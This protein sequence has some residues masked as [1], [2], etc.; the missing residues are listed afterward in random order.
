M[1]AF[2][3]IQGYGKTLRLQLDVDTLPLRTQI[4]DTVSSFLAAFEA[5]IELDV[6]MDHLDKAHDLK[7][8][9]EQRSVSRQMQQAMLNN[10]RQFGRKLARLDSLP[11]RECLADDVPGVIPAVHMAEHELQDGSMLRVPQALKQIRKLFYCERWS[12][13]GRSAV[14]PNDESSTTSGGSPQAATGTVPPVNPKTCTSS[15]ADGGRGCLVSRT[16]I[17]GH[18]R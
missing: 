11:E 12:K 15:G 10:S 4:L 14:H 6:D 18:T 3:E 17:Q 1:Q 13:H 7:I 16:R 5:R 8:I 2:I 9:R